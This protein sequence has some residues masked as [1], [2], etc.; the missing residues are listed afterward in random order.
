MTKLVTAVATV[1]LVRRGI[2]SLDE[3]VRDQVTE[4]GDIKILQEMRRGAYHLS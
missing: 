4:L 3:D 2:L 1:Q